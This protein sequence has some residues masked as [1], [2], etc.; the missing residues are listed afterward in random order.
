MR[1]DVLTIFPEYF[2]GILESSLLGK[3]RAR[4]HLEVRTHQLR[5]WTTDRHRSVDDSPYGGGHGM[6]MKVEP[7]VKAIE[8]LAVPGMRKILLAARGRPLRQAGVVELAQLPA[9][10]LVCG[11]YEGVD[12]RVLEYVDDSIC[13]GDYVLSGGEAAAAIVIDAVSRL[14]PGVIGNAESLAE[15]SFTS[16]GLEYPQYTRPEDFRGARV[17]QVLLSGDHAAIARWR[18]AAARETTR[19]L[20]PDLLAESGD[21]DGSDP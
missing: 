4:G 13:V 11:R 2:S 15:E 19:R 7:L 12:E 8:A 18:H 10:L 21:D 9:L 6:V 16:G 3:A 5:D 17:P 20:R 1:I 14:V